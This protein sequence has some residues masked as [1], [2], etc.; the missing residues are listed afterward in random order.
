[1]KT[2][3]DWF[4]VGLA[5]LDRS[6]G[7]DRDWEHYG[8]LEE[9]VDAFDHAL[10]VDPTH[11]AS[12]RERGFIL[13]KL[14]QHEAALDSFVAA[15]SLKLADADLQLAV[16]KSLQAL[17]QFERALGE[18]D[19]VLR[20]RPGDDQALVG[21]AECL[22]ALERD[23][24]ALPAWNEAIAVLDARQVE[25]QGKLIRDLTDDWRAKEARKARAVVSSR[26]AR[27]RWS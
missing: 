5:A 2:A 11:F 15:A 7:A 17:K 10:A 12:L 3:E 23:A 8:D 25:H 9:A 13:A 1:V 24:L 26:G 21:R 4:N 22:T 20:V 14:D 19:E 18:F 6:R 16:A 27:R